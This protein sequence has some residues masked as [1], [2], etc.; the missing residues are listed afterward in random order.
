MSRTLKWILGIA[1]VLVILAIL[2]GGVWAWQN[3]AQLLANN[4]PYAAQPGAPNGRPFQNGP[5][6]NN[7]GGRGPMFGWGF[8]DGPMTR[9]RGRFGPLGV[10]G[11]GLFFVGGLFRLVIPLVV[12]AVVAL[13]FYQLGRR[14]GARTVRQESPSPN[15]PPSSPNP[16][17][18]A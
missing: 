6:F 8:R 12:L 7:G 18:A 16:P 1:A 5:R 3:R 13:L 10:F 4:G 9:G 15:P 14:S 11:M 2:A 17:A